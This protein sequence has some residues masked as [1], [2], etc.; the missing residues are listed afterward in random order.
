MA[1]VVALGFDW[2]VKKPSYRRKTSLVVGG[3]LTQAL[4][5]NMAIAA[6]ALDHCAT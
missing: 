6:S 2:W 4:A 5:Y 1:Q 3:T